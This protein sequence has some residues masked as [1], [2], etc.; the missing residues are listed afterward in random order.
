VDS[1]AVKIEAVFSSE[2]FE[3]IKTP[4]GVS[5]QKANINISRIF[6]LFSLVCSPDHG[7]Y[8]FY[9]YLLVLFPAKEPGQ[10]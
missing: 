10:K 7:K 8:I 9:L 4:E 3:Y 2:T 5:S 1:D 6:V